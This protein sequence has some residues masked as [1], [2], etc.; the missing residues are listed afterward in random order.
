MTAQ[1]LHADGRPPHEAEEAVTADQLR[2]RV[3]LRVLA[4]VIALACGTYA[5]IGAMLWTGR[6]VP[7]GMWI[8]AGGFATALTSWLVNSKGDKEGP[9]EV[10]APPGE[11]LPVTEQQTYDV[12]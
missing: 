9:T 10:V 2:S 6:D 12:R 11:P 7:D 1:P 4:A 3:V 8:A 5:L